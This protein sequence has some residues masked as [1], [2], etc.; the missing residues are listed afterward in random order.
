MIKVKFFLVNVNYC[1]FPREEV[2]QSSLGQ[3]RAGCAFLAREKDVNVWRL[4][5]NV[6]PDIALPRET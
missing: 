5:F 1:L 3:W 6:G 2:S 4:E